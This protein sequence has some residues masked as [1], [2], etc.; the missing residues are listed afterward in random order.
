MKM[1]KEVGRKYRQEFVQF[2]VGAG[3]HGHLEQRV[4]QI[5]QELLKVLQ[6]LVDAVDVAVETVVKC[7]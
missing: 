6:Q 5:A 3:V 7:F 4:E 2:R 1:L